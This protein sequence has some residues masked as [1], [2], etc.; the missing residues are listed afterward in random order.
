M[1]NNIVLIGF[2]G[3]GK[4]SVGRLLAEATDRFFLDTDHLIEAAAGRSVAE[5][6]AQEGEGGFRQREMALAKWLQVSVKNAVIATGGGMPMVCNNLRG[7]GETLW[8]ECDLEEIFERLERSGEREKRPLA[9]SKEVL[10][11][12]YAEREAVY[13]RTARRIVDASGNAQTVLA[14]ILGR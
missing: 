5:I 1:N 4:S 14:R 12:R 9:A 11:A 3:S 6:F 13:R 8:L 10:I 2:M 7:I